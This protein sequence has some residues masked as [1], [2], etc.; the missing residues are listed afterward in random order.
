MLFHLLFTHLFFAF[1]TLAYNEL[2]DYLI[3]KTL[4]ATQKV[5]GLS[6]IFIWLSIPLKTTH[7]DQL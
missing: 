3:K 7:I 1:N 4:M 6:E 2:V 5:I